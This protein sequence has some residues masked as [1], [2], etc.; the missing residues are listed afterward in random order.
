MWKPTLRLYWTNKR[1]KCN[2]YV[3]TVLP[4]D[5]AMTFAF[6]YVM[7]EMFSYVFGTGCSLKT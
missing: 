2:V 4:L 5:Y 7:Y 6:V 3:Q 1:P